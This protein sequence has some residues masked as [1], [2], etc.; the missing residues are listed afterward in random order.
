M[1][2]NNLVSGTI[3]LKRTA[4]SSPMRRFP[5][6][7]TRVQLSG[8]CRT[9]NLSAVLLAKQNTITVSLNCCSYRLTFTAKAS[10]MRRGVKSKQCIRRS[11]SGKPLRLILKS[12]IYTSM[13]IAAD[14]V[15]DK[16]G[17]L[18]FCTLKTVI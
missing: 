8:S 10:D 4:R 11:R 17:R 1:H 16:N 9:I 5:V 6:R 15:T 14:S 2:W 7:L 3:I 18:G 13:S 12:V